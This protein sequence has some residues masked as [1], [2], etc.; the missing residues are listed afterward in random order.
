VIATEP[1]DASV[2]PDAADVFASSTVA[3][4]AVATAL[5]P[6]KGVGFCCAAVAASDASSGDDLSSDA[7]S[8]DVLSVDLPS[9]AFDVAD[10]L[11]LGG[12]PSVLLPQLAALLSP[13]RPLR[14]DESSLGGAGS[15]TPRVSR[16]DR[17]AALSRA[18]RCEGCGSGAGLG[19]V[20]G[21]GWMLLSTSAAKLSLACDW[22]RPTDF[23]G[24][25]E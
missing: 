5:S 22:S 7:L 24:G 14:E 8:L 10:L 9:P 19:A 13:G 3:G 2:E 12:G 16:D 21:S 15:L 25:L 18:G 20:E 11:P 4:I 1:L 17:S 6:V 23:T